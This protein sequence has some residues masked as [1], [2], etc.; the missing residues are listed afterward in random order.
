MWSVYEYVYESGCKTYI[1]S[2]RCHHHQHHH[3][4]II[5]III[6]IN[7]ASSYCRAVG[8]YRAVCKYLCICTKKMSIWLRVCTYMWS[9]WVDSLLRII[10]R[11]LYTR[12]S[13]RNKWR[14]SYESLTSWKCSELE[15]YMSAQGVVWSY[16]RSVFQQS[17]VEV[18]CSENVDELGLMTRTK[19]H[20]GPLRLPVFARW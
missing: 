15:R 1:S 7:I 5:I 3:I 18:E 6:I 19:S 9:V 16:V 12:G 20:M 17:L 10:T 13:R 8:Y 2:L 4:I 14:R 11:I